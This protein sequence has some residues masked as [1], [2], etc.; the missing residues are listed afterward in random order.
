MKK[1]NIVALFFALHSMSLEAKQIVCELDKEVKLI[2]KYNYQ[3]GS[4]E[5]F[6]K[7]EKLY[8][9]SFKFIKKNK[10]TMIKHQASGAV[11][12]EFNL[13][14]CTQFKKNNLALD[15]QKK[16]SMKFYTND[17]IYLE[18][19]SENS[20]RCKVINPTN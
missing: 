4:F 17:E 13:E 10:N 7:K 9:C 19:V 16:G 8:H 3:D 5:V 6:Q 20:F 15:F 18:V 11:N 1:I 2:L 14:P 12:T